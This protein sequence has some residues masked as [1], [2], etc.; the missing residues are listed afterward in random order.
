M[1]SAPNGT[2]DRSQRP[3]FFANSVLVDAGK[4]EAHFFKTFELGV[5]RLEPEKESFTVAHDISDITAW[6][7]QLLQRFSSGLSFG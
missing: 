4:R 3:L 1:Y 6:L 5:A 7:E 2:F